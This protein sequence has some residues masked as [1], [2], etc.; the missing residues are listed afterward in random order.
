[1]VHY[2]LMQDAIPSVFNIDFLQACSQ[3]LEY[4]IDTKTLLGG[5]AIHPINEIDEIFDLSNSEEFKTIAVKINPFKR[6]VLH[7][8][9]YNNY[10]AEEYSDSEYYTQFTDTDDFDKFVEHYFSPDNLEGPLVNSSDYYFTDKLSVTYLLEFD[11]FATDIKQIPEFS[12]VENTDYFHVA[13]DLSADYRSYYTT[14][15]TIDKVAQVYAKDLA[16]YGYT[17]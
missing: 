8:F 5:E 7:Y 12:T 14:Q 1:M 11:T 2:T 17:F 10:P 16:K 4:F 6:V 9:A 3:K 15:A 13:Q